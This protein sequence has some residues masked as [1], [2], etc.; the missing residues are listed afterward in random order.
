ME[1]N[2]LYYAYTQYSQKVQICI[3]KHFHI[4]TIELFCLIF[5]TLLLSGCE[6]KD[7]NELAD[8]HREM[9]SKQEYVTTDVQRSKLDPVLNLDL[10][11][12]T[13]RQIS[14]SVDMSDLEVD[15][16]NVS[17]GEQVKAGQVL[18]SFKS[19]NLKK[20]I[21]E[22]TFDLQEKKLMLEH[23]QKLAVLETKDK[24]YEKI[25]DYERSILQGLDVEDQKYKTFSYGVIISE[26]TDDVNLASLYLEE[27]QARLAACQVKA[28]EDGIITFISQNIVSGVVEPGVT[29]AIEAC[30]ENQFVVETSDNYE[31]VEGAT[32]TGFTSEGDPLDVSVLSSE[33]SD[34]GQKVVFSPVSDIID[35][36]S[37]DHLYLSIRKES[38]D[39]VIYVDSK[40][41]YKKNDDYFVYVVDDQGFLTA[42]YVVCGEE[43]DN[44]TIIKSGLNGNEKVAI[45]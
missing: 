14:Y 12:E 10:K 39:N 26:L 31:F 29:F 33:P 38:L 18:V 37:T 35:P 30:G 6:D 23:Y 1:T 13:A 28:Q 44:N 40:A 45:K 15:Q 11:L 42:T 36:T 22:L 4:K 32:Y 24:P 34:D 25:N 9:Y 5:G 20:E 19:E 27:K 17:I 41:I 7:V 8:L 3:M 21:D 16:V 43:V 2:R